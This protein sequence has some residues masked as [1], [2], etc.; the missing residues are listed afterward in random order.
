MDEAKARERVLVIPAARLET[1]GMFH[2]FRPF[3]PDYL[4]ALLDPRFFSFRARG[5]VETDPSYK[6]L[7]P[8]VILRSGGQFFHYTRG[9]AGAETRLQALRSIGIG[10]HISEED[11]TAGDD[12]YRSGMLREL[13]EEVRIESKYTERCVGF[14]YDPSTPV[15][16]VHLGV[17]HL[18]ELEKPLVWPREEAIHEAGFAAL[19]DLVHERTAFETWSQLVLAEMS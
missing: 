2:G 19:R 13:N 8:Y 14:I 7:I 1:A 18:L 12:L 15:G 4:Q 16:E 6:Q 3:S 9:K 17:V 10:G 11:A 5:E